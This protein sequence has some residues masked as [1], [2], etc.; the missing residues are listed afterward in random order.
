MD[1]LTEQTESYDSNGNLRIFKLK[2]GTKKKKTQ[3]MNTETAEM[4]RKMHE[5]RIMR[6]YYIRLFS[7]IVILLEYE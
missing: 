3:I 6:N 1:N 7:E 4:F 2:R 5:I